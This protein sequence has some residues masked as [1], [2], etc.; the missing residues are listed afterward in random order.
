MVQVDM[1]FALYLAD[2]APHMVLYVP[3]PGMIQS[4][5]TAS[6]PKLKKILKLSPIRQEEIRHT[7]EAAHT[8]E[9]T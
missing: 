6:G 2:L 3:P 5:E 7:K 8:K 1:E 4:K 9:K